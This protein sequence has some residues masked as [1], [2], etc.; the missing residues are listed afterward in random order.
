MCLIFRSL[1]LN[2]VIIITKF[3]PYF[4]EILWCLWIT[5]L[6]KKIKF[7]ASSSF[8]LVRGFL[9]LGWS[10]LHPLRVSLWKKSI[11]SSRKICISPGNI[12]RGLLSWFIRGSSLLFPYVPS[13]A[14]TIFAVSQIVVKQQNS[15]FN[16]MST[17][18]FQIFWEIAMALNA[19]KF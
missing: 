4:L 9:I 5:F 15:N 14:F 11:K 10:T 8:Q 1:Y 19:I 2:V 7:H 16:S 13:L 17:Q 12:Q 6:M 3:F 18:L